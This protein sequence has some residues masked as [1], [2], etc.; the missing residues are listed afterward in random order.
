M[1]AG[2]TKSDTKPASGE[3]PTKLAKKIKKS[4]SAKSAFAHFEEDDIVERFRPAST[5]EYKAKVSD[6]EEEEEGE[7]DAKA[8]DFINRFKQQLKLQRLE[9]ITRYKDMVNKGSNR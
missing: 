6:D 7:V 1:Q 3:V 5:R 2:R 8:D 4:T 9:S